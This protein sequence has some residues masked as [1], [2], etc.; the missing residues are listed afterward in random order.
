MEAV[1]TKYHQLHPLMT[2]RF[3]RRWAA[4]E[5]E[6]LGRGG[7]ASSPKLPACPGP[8]SGPVGANSSD[9][10]TSPGMTW[11]PNEFGPR[12]ADAISWSKR[13][14]RS[15]PT[16]R[17]W[18]THRRGGS[19]ITSVLD[20]QECTEGCRG[21]ERAGSCGEPSDGRS[22]A[23]RLGVQPASQS[24]DQGRPRPRRS[25][26]PVRIHRRQ[27][28]AF[29]EEDQPAIS[30]DAK[31]KENIGD[32]R[33]PGREWHRRR[34]PEEVRAKDFPDKRLGK[35]IPEG[36]YDL[37]RNEGWV[38]VGV[39]HDTAEFAGVS[40]RVVGRDGVAGLS[41]SPPALDHRRCRGQ[42]RLSATVVE[43]GVAG[44]G[45][46]PGPADLG[47]PFPAG[48]EQVEQDRAPHVLLHHEELAWQAASLA[49]R[50]R[51]LDATSA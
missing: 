13:I 2:E 6:S 18:S 24:E 50:H 41:G 7:R 25:R 37:S 8:R 45:E 26:C 23:R 12:A 51:Q 22:P 1:R 48:H 43:S 19:A 33:N 16:C 40:I 14:R 3:R 17:F 46:R 39:D 11:L 34:R 35:A 30:V 29:Q 9:G 21:T 42:Q 4:C 28:R 15:S 47:L 49:S 36:V 10:P 5:A 38:S 32:F 20:L 27:V 44:F 31:K